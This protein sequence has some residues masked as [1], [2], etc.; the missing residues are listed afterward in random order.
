MRACTVKG[1]T[2]PYKCKGVCGL[3]Y[4]RLVNTGTTDT[5]VRTSTTG[6]AEQVQALIKAGEPYEN[7]P[8]KFGL[9]RHG[10]VTWLR[11]HKHLELARKFP[12]TANPID[13]NH[14]CQQ[15]GQPIQ[16]RSEST[17]TWR[18]RKYCTKACSNKYRNEQRKRDAMAAAGVALHITTIS[19]WELPRLPNAACVGVDP[20]AFFPAV[21]DRNLMARKI[22]DKCP[23]DTRRACLE[24]ALE[25]RVTG[26]WAGTT[27]EERRHIRNQ[28]RQTAA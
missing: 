27:E 1:C 6:R 19:G 9:T 12:A 3:H 14:C 8:G 28:R 24:Y 4:S 23:L 17:T 21:G 7:I 22:C 20:E 5:P 10:L 15:C 11:R 16:Q 25:T 18:Q 2:R 13:P 26:V